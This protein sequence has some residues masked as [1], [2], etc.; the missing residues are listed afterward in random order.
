MEIM[1]KRLK[2]RVELTPCESEVM[3]IVWKKQNVTVND[4]V[5]SI[6]RDLAYTTVLTTMRIL[7]EKQ[8]V[9]RGPKHGRAFTYTANVSREQVREGMLRSLIDQL[10]GG[11]ARSV[12]LS[13]IKTDSVT[14]DE[15]EAAKK[16]AA[17]LEEQE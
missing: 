9:K 6:S 11:S 10:F 16:I 8:V 15:I 14:L 1:P 12:V 17:S 2:N 5:A 13:L 3:D 7:E 4:V